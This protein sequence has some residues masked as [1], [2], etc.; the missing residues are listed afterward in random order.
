MPSHCSDRD[1]GMYPS[2]RIPVC[3]P[4]ENRGEEA[5]EQSRFVLHGEDSH[6]V[7]SFHGKRLVLP[8][9]IVLGM[10]EFQDGFE[11]PELELN[12]PSQP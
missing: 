4:R 2:L 5:P 12:D 9:G 8:A 11:Q 6:C 7:K 3:S 10:L 1:I